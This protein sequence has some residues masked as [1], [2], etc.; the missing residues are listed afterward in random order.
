[1]GLAWARRVSNLRPLACEARSGGSR[2]DPGTGQIVLICRDLDAVPAPAAIGRFPPILGLIGH[3][4]PI[5]TPVRQSARRDMPRWHVPERCG[6]RGSLA[7]SSTDLDG[8]ND[9]DGAAARSAARNE[10]G[11][12]STTGARPASWA[13]ATTR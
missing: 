3:W 11:D 9:L 1:M 12:V 13:G 10:K 5:D 2:A 8:M 4:C 6:P 7:V